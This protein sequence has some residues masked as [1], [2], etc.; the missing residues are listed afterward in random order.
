MGGDTIPS[1]NCIRSKGIG[2]PCVQ[3]ESLI[4]KETQNKETP[5]F[6]IK[7][8]NGIELLLVKLVCSQWRQEVLSLINISHQS[9]PHILLIRKY[10]KCKKYQRPSLKNIQYMFNRK[11][12]K[13]R[14]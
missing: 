4:R 12:H 11:E 1:A 10:G 2:M 13:A 9:K 6:T 8:R 7:L 5:H 14:G 3:L